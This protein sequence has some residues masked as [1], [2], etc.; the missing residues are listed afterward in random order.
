MGADYGEVPVTVTMECPIEQLLNIVAELT[1]QPELVAVT[2]LRVYSAN[3]K[4][5]TMNVRLAVSAVV[6]KKLL[7]A[8]GASL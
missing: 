4:M 2:E 3:Q 6:P 1:S 7:P 8:K 5:K